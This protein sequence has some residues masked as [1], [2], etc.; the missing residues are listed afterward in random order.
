MHVCLY[1]CM[2]AC[3]YVH[4]YVCMYV[5]MYVCM[6]VYICMCARMKMNLYMYIVCIHNS[7]NDPIKCFSNKFP[8]FAALKVV[9]YHW[10]GNRIASAMNAINCEI[11][12]LYLVVQITIISKLV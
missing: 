11:Q 5:Y 12:S 2:Y 4:M 1:I 8:I 3:I 9:T 10:I 6:Y 7:V